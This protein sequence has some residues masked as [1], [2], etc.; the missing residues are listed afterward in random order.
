[1]KHWT[2]PARQD[3]AVRRSIRRDP[4]RVAAAAP[5]KKARAYSREQ[6]IWMGMAGVAL[7]AAVIVVALIGISWATYFKD[8]PAADAAARQFGQCYNSDAA[9][10]V[11][12]GDTIY[13]ANSRVQIAS[14]ETP[15]I[16]DAQCDTERS[17]GISA[18]MGLAGLLNSGKVSV[19]APFR[20]QYG[21]SV[22]KVQV[23]DQ[24][25]GDWMISHS[26]AR[27]YTGEKQK[28]C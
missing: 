11:V 6:E 19:G 7:F 13:V 1:M 4:V 2:P 28:W 3:I 27:A 12:D 20:D 17:R 8:D 26:L 25:V 16:D 9:R 18:A 22:S 10:C 14:I 5:P 24:D 21:R 23:D 15:G